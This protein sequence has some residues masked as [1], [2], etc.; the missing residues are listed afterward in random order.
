MWNEHNPNFNPL[1][2]WLDQ[3]TGSGLTDC[4]GIED[5]EMGNWQ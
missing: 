4:S 3:W 5:N 1:N 2:V